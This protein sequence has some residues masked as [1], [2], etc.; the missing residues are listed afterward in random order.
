MVLEKF[1]EQIYLESIFIRFFENSEQ[2]NLENSNLEREESALN[3]NVETGNEDKKETVGT[4][5]NPKE[6]PTADLI[7]SIKSKI[8]V[9]P[10]EIDIV[11]PNKQINKNVFISNVPDF[12]TNTVVQNVNFRLGGKLNLFK[13]LSSHSHS[14]EQRLNYTFK[15]KELIE[16]PSFIIF[17]TH[18]GGNVYY[19]F[20]LNT[21]AKKSKRWIMGTVSIREE[22]NFLF[23]VY[24]V[25]KEDVIKLINKGSKV[26]IDNNWAIGTKSVS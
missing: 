18:E 23:D 5:D 24:G 6:V 10:F 11:T 17:A 25:D 3:N 15:L 19:F 2:D 8:V 21:K 7:N 1:F 9:D 4:F 26:N 13:K 12:V 14:D 22:G 16:N 20:R